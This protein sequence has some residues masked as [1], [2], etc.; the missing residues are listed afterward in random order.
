M[1]PVSKDDSTVNM[2]KS[3]KSITLVVNQLSKVDLN[4]SK[5]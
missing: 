4:V 5:L 2:N 1:E 3:S